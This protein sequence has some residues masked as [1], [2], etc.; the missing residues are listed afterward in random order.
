MKT[1]T[2]CS[3]GQKTTMCVACSAAWNCSTPICAACAEEALQERAAVER[4]LREVRMR[5]R[6]WTMGQRVRWAVLT[7][8]GRRPFEPPRPNHNEEA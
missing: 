8:F 2:C 5:D 3:C 4:A 1:M 7:R 6:L